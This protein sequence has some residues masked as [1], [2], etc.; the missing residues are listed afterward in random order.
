MSIMPQFKK[1]KNNYSFLGKGGKRQWMKND[2]KKEKAVSF[3]M[4]CDIR[5]SDLSVLGLQNLS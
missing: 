1:K 5:N 3:L 4:S 2:N